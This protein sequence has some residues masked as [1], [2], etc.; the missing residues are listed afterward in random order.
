M[1]QYARRPTAARSPM[2]RH[3]VPVIFQGLTPSTLLQTFIIWIQ[4]RF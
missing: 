2:P 4:D 3:S 1:T